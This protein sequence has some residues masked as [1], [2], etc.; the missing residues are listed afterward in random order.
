MG[1]YYDKSQKTAPPFNTGDLGMLK[2]KNV[3]TQRIARKLDT[4]IFAP[5]KVVRLVDR[6]G[7]SVELGLPK[8]RHVH[9]VFYTYLLELYCA[10]VKGLHP[11]PIAVTDI[12]YIVR[13]GMK[14]VIGYD[15]DGQQVLEDFEIEEIIES[16]Y[17][18]GRRKVQHLIKWK[19]YPEKSKWIEE[20]LEYLPR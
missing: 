4:K 20:A 19:R 3:R 8:R 7:I 17:S 1:C 15:V 2:G 11:Q 12:V 5:F 18:T 6:C 14:Y 13:F 16:E 10:S 9:N